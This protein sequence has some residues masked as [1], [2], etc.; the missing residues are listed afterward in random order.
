MKQTVFIL[1]IVLAVFST[2]IFGQ[3]KND[4]CCLLKK[5]II[6][7]WQ[8]NDSLVG[9]GLNQN[10]Q[11]FKNDTFIF[12][13]GS[14]ADDVR[15]V[16]QLKGKYRLDKD[17]IYFTITSRTIVEGPIEIADP[18]ISLNIFSIGK[19]KVREVPEHNLKELADPCYITLFTNSHIKINQET[20][21]KVKK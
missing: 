20:Y 2:Q 14:E 5:D 17:K 4:T 15:N 21:Y 8:R 11:F 13:I 12:N 19:G 16:I 10:F 1:T 7:T 9:S 18:G 3:Q 6:G